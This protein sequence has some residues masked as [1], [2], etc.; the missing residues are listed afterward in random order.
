LASGL[1]KG[2]ITDELTARR[3]VDERGAVVPDKKNGTGRRVK[4]QKKAKGVKHD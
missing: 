1:L 4:T 2:L 3:L